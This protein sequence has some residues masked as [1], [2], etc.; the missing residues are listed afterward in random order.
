MFQ[1]IDVGVALR[2]AEDVFREEVVCVVI[3]WLNDMC[4]VSIGGDPDLFKRILG[5]ALVGNRITRPKGLGS[6]LTPDLWDLA[7]APDSKRLDWLLHL[8]TRLWKKP[9]WDLRD[10]YS[11]ISH[12]EWDLK[13]RIGTCQMGTCLH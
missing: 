4:K 3:S 7:A 10:I 5:Y 8:D 6:P 9:K 12:I 11:S 2:L 13:K 1:Q